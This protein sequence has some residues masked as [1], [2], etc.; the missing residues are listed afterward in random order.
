MG[1]LGGFLR[2]GRMRSKTDEACSRHPFE[3]AAAHCR[4]CR[5]YFCPECLVWPRGRERP[6]ICIPCALSLSGIRH[7]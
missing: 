2:T 3:R 4:A 5:E 6:P 7:H 1:A